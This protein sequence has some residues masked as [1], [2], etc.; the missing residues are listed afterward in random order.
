[1]GHFSN[2]YVGI[3]DGRPTEIIVGDDFMEFREKASSPSSSLLQ[4]TATNEKRKSSS[5]DDVE[6]Q[7]H[8]FFL[9]KVGKR[10]LS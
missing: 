1:M 9:E 5:S 2:V 10:P 3:R 4:E 6:A 7:I 8:K